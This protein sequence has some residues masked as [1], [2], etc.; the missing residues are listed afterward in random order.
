MIRQSERARVTGAI[1]AAAAAFSMTLT[2]CSSGEPAERAAVRRG[3]R[4]PGGRVALALQG[5]PAFQGAR[6]IPSVRTHEPA[7][8]PGWRPGTGGVVIAKGSEALADEGRLIAGELKLGYRGAVPAR[9]GDVELALD[10]GEGQARVV[11]RSSPRRPG[12]GSPVPPRPGSSTG[13]GR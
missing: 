2:G 9:A 10:A 12:R 5:L 8:G 6:T 13:P 1:V 7:R 11:H 4:H 3:R